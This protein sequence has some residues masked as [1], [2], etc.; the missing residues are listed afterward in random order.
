[1]DSSLLLA[2]FLV[3]FVMC[4]CVSE[5]TDQ[6]KS[7]CNDTHASQTIRQTAR[8]EIFNDIK[9]NFESR[10]KKLWSRAKCKTENKNEKKPTNLTEFIFRHCC[11]SS[12]CLCLFFGN[13]FTCFC[14]L[15]SC[16]F[17]M[18]VYIV[19]PSLFACE[20]ETKFLFFCENFTFRFYLLS[21]YTDTH[22]NRM[23][24]GQRQCWFLFQHVIHSRWRRLFIIP[25]MAQ[26]K[27]KRRWE[28]VWI[29][30]EKL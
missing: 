30:I 1:M 18:R 12:L 23:L 27:A 26:D 17:F 9:K 7:Y 14:L 20:T 6:K 25:F 8:K 21:V 16:V 24:H 13:Y 10:K 4:R 3:F 2:L 15:D 5:D 22:T 29:K 28:N 11:S 19:F